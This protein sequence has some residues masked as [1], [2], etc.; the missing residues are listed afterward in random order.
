MRWL[1]L[2]ALLGPALALPSELYQTHCASCHGAQ[3][4]GGM[5]PAL[6]PE[7]LSRLK[8]PEAARM[9]RDSRPGVQMP[10][11]KAQLRDED[12][13]KLVELIYTPLVPAPA[14]SEADIRASRIVQHAPG[15]CRR[16]RNSTPIRSIS[17]WWSKRATTT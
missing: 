13:A 4:L 7:N 17:S 6:L 11:F 3:R 14:W 15:T 12:V 1:L 9:I 5:G 2:L 8:K 16:S 10:A